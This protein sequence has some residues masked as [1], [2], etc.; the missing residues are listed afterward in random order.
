MQFP[1]Q[2]M[3]EWKCKKYTH[4]IA[5]NPQWRL[6]K[7]AGPNI[8]FRWCLQSTYFVNCYGIKLI[9]YQVSCTRYAFRLLNSLQWCSGRKSWKSEKRWKLW[10]SRRMKTKTEC[11]EI[12]PNPSKNRAMAEGDNPSFWDKFTFF[13]WQFNSY[14][15]SKAGT[16]VLSNWA[17]KT[18][19]D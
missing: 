8:S 16:E 12:K 3:C 7:I 18:L 2:F 17:V 19:G 1:I 4:L 14:S 11:H 15:Y 5:G 9:S 10:K 13:S 6:K